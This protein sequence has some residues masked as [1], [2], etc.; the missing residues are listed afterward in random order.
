M[1]HSVRELFDAASFSKFYLFV[2]NTY[3]DTLSQMAQLPHHKC[4]VDDFVKKL[5][6]HVLEIFEAIGYNGLLFVCA[7]LGGQLLCKDSF[8]LD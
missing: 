2:D 3:T 7:D 6:I 4:L 5:N 1:R 8:Q